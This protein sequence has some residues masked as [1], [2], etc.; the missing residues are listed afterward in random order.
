MSSDTTRGILA[1]TPN[2]RHS[3]TRKQATPMLETRNH[4]ASFFVRIAWAR[5]GTIR[6]T[7]LYHSKRAAPVHHKEA[8]FNLETFEQWE[9]AACLFFTSHVHVQRTLIT[10]FPR[11]FQNWH[12]CGSDI[13]RGGKSQ[14]ESSHLIGTKSLPPE[15]VM[16]ARSSR[17]RKMNDLL[18]YIIPLHARLDH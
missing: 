11:V 3:P 7:Y 4:Q 16:S 9:G 10:R 17:T 1:S 12:Q 15:S 5:T 2:V 14:D 6:R 8:W 18:H 13:K